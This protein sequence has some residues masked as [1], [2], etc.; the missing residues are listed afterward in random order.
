M[1]DDT[2]IQMIKESATSDIEIEYREPN[3]YMIHTGFT[4]PDFDEL[5]IILTK[6]NGDWILTDNGHTMMWLSYD[7]FTMTRTRK[8]LLNKT[9]NQNNVVLDDGVLLV[10][11]PDNVGDMGLALRSIIT[12]EL[13]MADLIFMK[14]ESVKDTFIED[15]KSA[16][17]NSELSEKCKFDTKIVGSDNME[18]RADIY[19]EAKKPILIFGIHSTIQCS[20]ATVTMLS[21]NRDGPEYVFMTV[22]D[23]KKQI[24]EKDIRRAINASVKTAYGA[25]EAVDWAKKLLALT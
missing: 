23:D 11:C 2:I 25:E 22:F 8:I 14:K 5:H 19:I 1:N 16:F 6:R 12:T 20:R 18:Y 21:L 17:T 3:T 9:L 13:Q 24:P 15:L 7:D 10:R 4:Y